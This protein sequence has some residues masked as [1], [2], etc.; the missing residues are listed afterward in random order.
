MTQVVQRLT[1]GSNQVV[2][3]Q[4]SCSYQSHLTPSTA[5]GGYSTVRSLARWFVSVSANHSQFSVRAACEITA[6][7]DTAITL[8]LEEAFWTALP[9]YGVGGEI[10]HTN[11]FL[12]LNG[13]WMNSITLLSTFTRFHK[14]DEEKK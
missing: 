11:K 4:R 10:R 3:G 5:P 14:K 7:H 9:V 12:K 6:K 2:A 1:A 8:Y 13:Q